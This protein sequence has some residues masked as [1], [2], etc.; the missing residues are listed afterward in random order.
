MSVCECEFQQLNERKCCLLIS[1]LSRNRNTNLQC[2]ILFTVLLTAAPIQND[3]K[4]ER[5]LK[6]WHM[7]TDLKVLSESFLMYTNMTG[8]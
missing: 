8:F 3:K 4:A 2:N 5:L 1:M 7:G 6:P